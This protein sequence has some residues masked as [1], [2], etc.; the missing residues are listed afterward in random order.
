M[1]GGAGGAPGALGGPPGVG[2]GT[3]GA[4]PKMTLGG[5]PGGPQRGG[6]RKGGRR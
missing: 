4:M 1:M 5:G 2:P 3:A 6:H